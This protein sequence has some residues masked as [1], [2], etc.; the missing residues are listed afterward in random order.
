MSNERET[1]FWSD[2]LVTISER[3]SPATPTEDAYGRISLT[4]QG[5]TTLLAR[6]D[7]QN[8]S[9]SEVRTMMYEC[10]Q[11]LMDKVDR[12]VQAAFKE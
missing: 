2:E 11:E 6:K 3:F 5:G 1:R 9:S 12:A 7:F 10:Q 4:I 8:C